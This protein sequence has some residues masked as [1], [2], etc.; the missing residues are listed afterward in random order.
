MEAFPRV[1]TRE[2]AG[3]ALPVRDPLLRPRECILR[4]LIRGQPRDRVV[5]ELDRFGESTDIE[6]GERDQ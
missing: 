1:R 6:M 4:R 5:G 2:Q 3:I